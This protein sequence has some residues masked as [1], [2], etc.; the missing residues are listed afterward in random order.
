MPETTINDTDVVITIPVSLS[1]HQLGLLAA[2][3]QVDRGPFEAA[4]TAAVDLVAYGACDI[5]AE[6]FVYLT[7]CGITAFLYILRQK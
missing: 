5:D 6:G 3:H 7:G 4:G 1:N 2:L